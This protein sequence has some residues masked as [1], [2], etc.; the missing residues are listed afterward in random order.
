MIYIGMDISSKSFLVHAIDSK[1]K[2][3][4]KGEIKPT[5]SGIR[6]DDQGVRPSIE[7]GGI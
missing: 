7:I 3:V 5:R 2:V 4:F 6:A 1:K